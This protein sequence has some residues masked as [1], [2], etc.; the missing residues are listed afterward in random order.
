MALYTLVRDRI[1]FGF[2]PPFDAASPEE[3]LRHGLGH[4]NPQAALLAALFREAGL[5]AE[6]HFVTI[7]GSILRGLFPAPAR[8]NHS[9]VRVWIGGQPVTLDGYICDPAFFRGAR[10]QLL[11][12]G[13]PL[14]LGVHAR[15]KVAWDGVSACMSQLADP[16]MVLADH[17]PMEPAAFYG[18]DAHTQRLGPLERFFYRRRIAPTANAIIEALR[19]EGRA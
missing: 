11:A 18:S 8:I 3:T 2:A 16:A 15:G 19:R 1:L 4:C 13:Q 12:S 17:G 9:Y 7:S 6:Q 5:R 14:G 10:N